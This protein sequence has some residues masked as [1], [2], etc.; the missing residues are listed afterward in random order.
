MQLYC[1]HVNT[2]NNEDD[3]LTNNLQIH[4]IITASI[5]ALCE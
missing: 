4:I 2:Q 1:N 3:H 5:T